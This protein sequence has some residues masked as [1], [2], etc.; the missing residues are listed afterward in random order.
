MLV[1]FRCHFETKFL[2]SIKTWYIF[3]WNT[4]LEKMWNFVFS[5]FPTLWKYFCLIFLHFF[6]RM[7]ARQLFE[8]QRHMNVSN[9][10]FDPCM[11]LLASKAPLLVFCL[12]PSGAITHRGP[13]SHSSSLSAQLFSQRSFLGQIAWTSMAPFPQIYWLTANLSII[14]IPNYRLQSAGWRQQNK[15]G[16]DERKKGEDMLS[17]F[18]TTISLTGSKGFIS[19]LCR[20]YQCSCSKRLSRVRSLI[21]PTSL[22]V[23]YS[24]VTTTGWLHECRKTTD[25]EKT[26]VLVTETIYRQCDQNFGKIYIKR[27]AVLL[28]QCFSLSEKRFWESPYRNPTT[29]YW[30]CI[31]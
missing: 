5:N 12:W 21:T 4:A 27:A 6:Y 15:E 30:C 16:E 23:K 10:V 20:T 31:F 2:H 25:N 13:S 9:Y 19:P 11:V 1:S 8:C 7:N 3:V 24:T 17:F 26:G 29:R 22:R 28:K 14:H 18:C